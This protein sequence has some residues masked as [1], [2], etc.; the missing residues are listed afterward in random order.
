MFW[1]KKKRPTFKDWIK[2]GYCPVADYKSRE[3]YVAYEEWMKYSRKLTLNEFLKEHPGYGMLQVH[4]DKNDIIT[5]H[6]SDG[7]NM[8]TDLVKEH[9]SR[10]PFCDVWSKDPGGYGG[11]PG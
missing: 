8:T 6:P 7:T 9:Q 1:F 11:G 5:V 2:L 4:V 10:D 3:A